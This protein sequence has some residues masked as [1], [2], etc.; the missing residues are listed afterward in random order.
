M[1]SMQ[2]LIYPLTQRILEDVNIRELVFDS[3]LIRIIMQEAAGVSKTAEVLSGE[4]SVA[5]LNDEKGSVETPDVVRVE[6]LKLSTIL[7]EY[8]GPL[9]RIYKKEMIKYPWNSIKSEDYA[10]KYWSYVNICRFVAAFDSH[11]K[12]SF[13][14][15]WLCYAHAPLRVKK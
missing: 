5:V 1:K 3:D 12:L 4:G 13:K 10:T 8:I 14:C 9:L 6:L 2:I 7:L 11:Q 15:M